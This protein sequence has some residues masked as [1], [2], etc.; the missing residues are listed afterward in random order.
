MFTLATLIEDFRTMRQSCCLILS[1]STCHLFTVLS[2]KGLC[3]EINWDVMRIAGLAGIEL[4][5]ICAAKALVPISNRRYSVSCLDGGW[6]MATKKLARPRQA[7]E[8]KMIKVELA[9]YGQFLADEG[10]LPSLRKSLTS[11]ETN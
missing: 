7:V 5:Q 10:F 11:C 6:T 1:D 3:V 2:Y 8:R 4:C 9:G